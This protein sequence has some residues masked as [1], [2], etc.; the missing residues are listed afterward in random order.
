M[1]ENS[2]GSSLPN[3][4]EA[5]HSYCSNSVCFWVSGP[6]LVSRQKAW[7]DRSR[8]AQGYAIFSQRF[9]PG[10]E[11]KLAT[12]AERFSC[13]CTCTA[14]LGARLDGASVPSRKSL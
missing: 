12:S 11:E 6:G 13:N 4:H 5:D 9:R 14:K 1:S 10:S 7:F 8:Y 2:T 3:E